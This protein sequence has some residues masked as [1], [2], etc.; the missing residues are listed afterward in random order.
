MIRLFL[1]LF[2]ISCGGDEIIYKNKPVD[3]NVVYGFADM[4]KAC[5]SCHNEK[6][7]EIPLDEAGF[8]ASASVRARIQDGTMP[9]DA[10]SFSKDAA[11]KYIDGVDQ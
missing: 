1:M 9:P 3:N 10:S 8:K 4:E 6:A 11:L 2:L 7:P 5:F